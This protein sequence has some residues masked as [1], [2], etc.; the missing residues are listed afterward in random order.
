MSDALIA[1]LVFLGL[2][3]SCFYAGDGAALYGVFFILAAIGS[4]V[5]LRTS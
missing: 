1:V 5:A 3:V 2:S 4:Y